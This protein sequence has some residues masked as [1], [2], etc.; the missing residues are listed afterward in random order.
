MNAAV[1]VDPELKQQEGAVY[2]SLQ[3]V[4]QVDISNGEWFDGEFITATDDPGHAL[5]LMLA[6]RSYGATRKE[7]FTNTDRVFNNLWT[8]S[9]KVVEKW[10]S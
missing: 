1:E 5:H 10:N 2:L 4:V 3:P 7:V 6:F 8:A 9:K